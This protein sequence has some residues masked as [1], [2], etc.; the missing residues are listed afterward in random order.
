[1]KIVNEYIYEENLL[2]E[3]YKLHLRTKVFLILILLTLISTIT[4][5]IE[6]D[7]EFAIFSLIVTV[8]G[9]FYYFIFPT[10]LSKITYRNFM[11]D[12]NNTE[13][14]MR[15]TITEK[16]ITLE[17]LTIK[18]KEETDTKDIK[19]VEEKKDVICLILKDK[20]ALLLKK[21]SFTKGDIETL[22]KI[23]EKSSYATEK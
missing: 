20:L 11:K 23:I 18:G 12:T 10:I 5:F 8:I 2:Q 19:K 7:L 4:S 14:K 13:M 22:Y 17:N 16:K 21:D 1:M 9:L 6:K 15:V 3:F